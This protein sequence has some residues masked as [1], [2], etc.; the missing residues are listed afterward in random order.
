ML[1]ISSPWSQR[2]VTEIGMSWNKKYKPRCGTLAKVCPCDR[3]FS[4]FT[5][6]S[7]QFLILSPQPHQKYYITH[8]YEELGFPLAYSD[9]R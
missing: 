9:E 8:Q 7:D 6:E 2:L 4:P 3:L 1:F 5:P